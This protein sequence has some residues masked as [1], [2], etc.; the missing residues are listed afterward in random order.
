MMRFVYFVA[1]AAAAASAQI[2]T[3]DAGFVINLNEGAGLQGSPDARAAFRRAADQWQARFADDISVTIDAD[4]RDLNQP[5]VIG[6][7]ESLFLEG[8]YD[9]IRNR[10]VADAA[11]EPDDAVVGF[12]PTAAQFSAVLP[13]GF[14]LTG[15]VVA[16]K[17]TLKAMGFA[18]LDAAFGAR[19]ATI[20]FNDRFA[21]DFD[22]TNGVDP[23]KIDFET[24]A[25]HEI[26]HALGFSSVVDTVDAFLQAGL[27]GNVSPQP[28]DLFRFRN[29]V[30][31][32]DPSSLSEF[33]TSPRF[34]STGGDAI[35]D[36]LGSEFRMS[37]GASTGDGRQAS[38]WKDDAL[39]AGARIGVLDPTLGFGQISPITAAD[40]R[41]LDLI[42]YDP[43]QQTVAT[44]EPGSLAL[45]G[46]A[47]VGAAF[48][49]WRRNRRVEARAA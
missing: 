38:H 7:N 20:T 26:G 6:Q 27:A 14:G 41:A 11:D 39:M 29:D 10:M 49:A 25:I 33:T 2:R 16:A 46:V 36:D 30:A 43:L 12:L 37:T 22:N 17:A 28:L 9:V 44:P 18:G 19:D 15:A 34:L 48:G 3:A 35:T 21:F 42:G 8:G 5:G 40:V 1:V 31:G 32:Q 23:D 13:A 4:F 47:G 45:L 24:V